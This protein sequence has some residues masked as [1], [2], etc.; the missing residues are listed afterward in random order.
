MGPDEDRPK[1]S[2]SRPQDRGQPILVR[3]TAR[4]RKGRVKTT[5]SGIAVPR[6]KSL[7]LVGQRFACKELLDGWL[8]PHIIR[9]GYQVLSQWC[10]DM[11]RGHF[12]I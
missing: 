8:L 11:K 9:N 6:G 7:R 4:A 1:R 2:P 5:E 10:M 3:D 12:K